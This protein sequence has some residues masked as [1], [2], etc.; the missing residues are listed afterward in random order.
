LKGEHHVHEPENLNPIS[1]RIYHCYYSES[2]AWGKHWYIEIT[3]EDGSYWNAYQ[4]HEQ[5]GDL[6]GDNA[7]PSLEELMRIF[8]RIIPSVNNGCIAKYDF[9]VGRYK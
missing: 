3:Y 8:N 4:W 7:E 2:S 1:G 6:D 5:Q 9:T